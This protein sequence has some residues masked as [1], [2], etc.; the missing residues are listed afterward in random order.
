V[1]VILWPLDV[2]CSLRFPASS[3][4]FVHRPIS[5][6]EVVRGRPRPSYVLRMVLPCASDCVSNLPTASNVNRSLQ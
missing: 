4:S 5:G 1:K 6:S 2:V 3:Y